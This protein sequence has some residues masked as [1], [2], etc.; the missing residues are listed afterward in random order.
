MNSWLELRRSRWRRYRDRL[1]AKGIEAPIRVAVTGSVVN[2]PGEAREAD[3]GIA[4]G[5]SF[6]H[7]IAEGEVKGIR[8]SGLEALVEGA[9]RLAAERAGTSRPE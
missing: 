9:E 5:K 6:G 4:A 7:L 1:Q 3:L 2:G 8:R